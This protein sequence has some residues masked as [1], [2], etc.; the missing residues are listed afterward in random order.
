MGRRAP[1]RFSRSVRG[2]TKN[3]LPTFEKGGRVVPHSSL[4]SVRAFFPLSQIAREKKIPVSFE[5]PLFFSKH[6][7][8]T[9]IIKASPAEPPLIP[10][11]NL[12]NS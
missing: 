11:R 1:C 3:P 4:R 6:F 2:K 5:D 8:L 9:L 12:G 10:T 7:L